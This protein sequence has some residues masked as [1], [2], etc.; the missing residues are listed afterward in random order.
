[1]LL[2]TARNVATIMLM[3]NV[4]MLK[5]IVYQWL[6]ALNNSLHIGCR[7]NLVIIHPHPHHRDMYHQMFGS[8]CLA[9]ALPIRLA[10]VVF[11]LNVFVWRFESAPLLNN[12]LYLLQAVRNE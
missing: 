6:A 5:V 1:M 4:C 7:L 8:K 12:C 10:L 11:D 3:L 2:H 9:K